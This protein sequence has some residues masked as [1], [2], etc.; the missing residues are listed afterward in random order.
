MTQKCLKCGAPISGFL[1][2]IAWFAGVKPSKVKAGYCNKCETSV[3]PN[4]T[5]RD[6]FGQASE[7]RETSDAPVAPVTSVPL[8]TPEQTP[9]APVSPVAP[10]TPVTT[11]VAPEAKD[12]FDELE[13]K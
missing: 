11:P 8:V 13:K 5:L 9:V 1:S 10:V 3:T 7:T 4:Q 2:K 6:G 12:I